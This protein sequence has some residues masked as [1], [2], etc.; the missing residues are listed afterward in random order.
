MAVVKITP[1]II[2]FPE[3]T[4]SAGEWPTIVV[5]VPSP[6]MTSVTPIEGVAL[7]SRYKLVTK[8]LS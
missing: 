6:V 3:P 2:T 4:V 5:V 7:K 1:L 8:A